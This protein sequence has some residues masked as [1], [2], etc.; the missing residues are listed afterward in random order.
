MPIFVHLPLRRRAERR[1][2][3]TGYGCRMSATGTVPW[4]LLLGT[5]RFGYGSA[6]CRIG[7]WATAA[8]GRINQTPRW[9]LCRRPNPRHIS[10]TP[11]NTI[12]SHSCSFLSSKWSGSWGACRLSH[13]I[14]HLTIRISLSAS[15]HH[16]FTCINPPSSSVRY[17]RFLWTALS[18]RGHGT[19]QWHH[20][21]NWSKISEAC[22]SH[23]LVIAFGIDSHQTTPS[24]DILWSQ[25][26]GWGWKIC[27]AETT[28]CFG[29]V[30]QN[31][32]MDS[33]MESRFIRF[34]VRFV[35]ALVFS[36]YLIQMFLV[37]CHVYH[38]Y[39]D[40]AIVCLLERHIPEPCL[41]FW[42]Q[43]WL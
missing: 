43:Y 28:A 39:R 27:I 36:Y 18:Y 41:K 19:R 29:P 33:V 6:L 14:R 13:S 20:W 3:P 17:L 23:S 38:N 25:I 31:W 1:N 9:P 16:S 22:T 40:D 21:P 15:T 35:F 30:E 24:H 26:V 42:G 5:I 4:A 7:W 11:C 8:N 32:S 12:I 37:Y 2:V 10:L 34:G